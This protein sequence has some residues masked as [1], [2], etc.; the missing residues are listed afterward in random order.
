MSHN[1]E[2]ALITEMAR[3][4]Q[5]QRLSQKEVAE[6]LGCAQSAISRLERGSVSPTLRTVI[7]YLGALDCQLV[8]A[9]NDPN[10]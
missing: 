6:K 10:D 4:R 3:I 9:P 8:I 2:R 5:A 7:E 1:K